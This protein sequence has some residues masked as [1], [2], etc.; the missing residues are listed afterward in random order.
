MILLLDLTLPNKAAP[1]IW[2]IKESKS[3]QMTRCI[4][5]YYCKKLPSLQRE[6]RFLKKSSEAVTV[7]IIMKHHGCVMAQVVGHQPF[8]TETQFQ[9]QASPCKISGECRGTGTGFSPNTSVFTCEYHSTNV[10]HTHSIKL[11]PM[12]YKLSNGECC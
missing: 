5:L 12:L 7:I 3:L 11:S 8:T 9:T 2:T 1:G 4:N 10:P 6:Y